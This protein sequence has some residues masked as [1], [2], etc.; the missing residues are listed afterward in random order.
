MRMRAMKRYLMLITLAILVLTSGIVIGC[1]PD[2]PKEEND[3]FF[4]CGYEDGHSWGYW[5]IAEDKDRTDLWWTPPD[6][7]DE[8]QKLHP[9]VNIR[10]FYIPKG[11]W[12]IDDVADIQFPDG[13]P[14]NDKQKKQVMEA[15][16]WGFYSGFMQGCDDSIEGKPSHE[17][18]LHP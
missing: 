1:A 5:L 7:V 6:R 3:A 17:E 12:T 9:G 14:F 18:L 8:A 13:T 2:L 15:Y 16:N 10:D 11:Y 4:T